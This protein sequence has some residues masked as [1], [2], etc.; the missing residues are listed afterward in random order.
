[1]LQANRADLQ[2]SVAAA[3]QA[4]P[5][6]PA[7]IPIERFAFDPHYTRAHFDNKEPLCYSSCNK[8]E[9]CSRKFYQLSEVYRI[10]NMT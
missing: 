9:N 4:A 1:M 7:G 8:W 10:T 5:D 3:G 2:M 6:M